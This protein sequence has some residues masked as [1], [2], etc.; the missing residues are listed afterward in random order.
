MFYNTD[1]SKRNTTGCV[2][3]WHS[4]FILGMNM[5]TPVLYTNMV[6]DFP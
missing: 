5:V 6:C 3:N 2:F 1:S 4:S